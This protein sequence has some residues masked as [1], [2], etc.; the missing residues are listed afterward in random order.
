MAK[1]FNI[2]E[3]KADFEPVEIVFRNKKHTLGKN[4][5]GLMDACE[6]HGTIED[7]D[8][9]QYIAAYLKL[10]PQLVRLLCPELELVLEELETGEQ[11]ALMKVCTEVLG[12]AGRLTFQEEEP[13]GV[14]KA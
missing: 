7:K 13:E 4:A 3:M 8:G 1:V 12:R 9:L 14:D 6:L 11:M 5:L 10:Q 2:D